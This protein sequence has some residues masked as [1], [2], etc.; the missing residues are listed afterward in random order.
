ML[1]SFIQ[2]ANIWKG[3][4][5]NHISSEVTSIGCKSSSQNKFWNSI[6]LDTPFI[7]LNYAFWSERERERKTRLVFNAT[8]PKEKKNK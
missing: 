4:L 7:L 3:N 2:Y 8:S 5:G 1:L 6:K